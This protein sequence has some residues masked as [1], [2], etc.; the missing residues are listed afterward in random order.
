MSS[1][2]GKDVITVTG[3]GNGSISCDLCPQDYI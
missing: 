2:L 1:Y 3:I